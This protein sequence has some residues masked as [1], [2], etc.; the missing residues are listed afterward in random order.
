MIICMHLQMWRIMP[1]LP[2]SK[3]VPVQVSSAT[4]GTMDALKS[5]QKSLQ[6]EK[7][8]ITSASASNPGIPPSSLM[9]FLK[10][11]FN[12]ILVIFLFPR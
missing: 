6:S 12:N 2:M 9:S 7:I 11:V 4:N 10:K 3:T 8:K 5:A 1:N